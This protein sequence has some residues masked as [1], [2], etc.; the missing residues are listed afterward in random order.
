MQQT[1]SAS[2]SA[3]QVQQRPRY[4]GVRQRPWGKW[5]AEIRDPVKAARVWL[6]T[7]DTAEAAAR[8]YDDAALRFKGAKAK[9]NFPAPPVHRHHSALQLQRP[10]DAAAASTPSTTAQPHPGGQEGFPDLGRYAHILQSGGDNMLDLQLQAIASAAGAGGGLVTPPGQSESS[11]SS[12][13]TA[14]ASSPAPS[15]DWSPWR[16][17]PS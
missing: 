4:R 8:A 11:S 7:F 9:L 15:V 2:A 3:E 12:A 6:G 17:R 10:D 5:A 14:S 13:R 16:G 1:A